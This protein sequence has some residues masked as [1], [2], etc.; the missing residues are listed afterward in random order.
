MKCVDCGAFTYG[1]VEFAGEDKPRCL[2]C[3]EYERGQRYERS[4][5]EH[6]FSRYDEGLC[7]ACEYM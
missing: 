5:C 1:L 4:K 3:H 7:G 6:G 2:P